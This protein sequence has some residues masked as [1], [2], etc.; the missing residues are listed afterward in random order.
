MR[1][2]IG[3]FSGPFCTVSGPLKFKGFCCCLNDIFLARKSLKRSFTSEIVYL[4]KPANNLLES[5]N[6]NFKLTCLRQKFEAVP[7]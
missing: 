2:V 6:N 3:Q 7:R 4:L 1:T 5:L